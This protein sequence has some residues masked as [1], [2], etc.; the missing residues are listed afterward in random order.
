MLR[1]ALTLLIGALMIGMF[2][3]PVTGYQKSEV[4]AQDTLVIW[5]F[6]QGG[7]L[8]VLSSLV[9]GFNTVEP[10]IQARL[11]AIPQADYYA[12]LLAAIK[13][14]QPPDVAFLS[15]DWMRR[16]AG[17]GYIVPI[18]A[19]YNTVSNRLAMNLESWCFRP[20]E[21]GPGTQ[22]E[23]MGLPLTVVSLG[24]FAYSPP[25]F[26]K[27]GFRPPPDWENMRDLSGNFKQEQIIPVTLWSPCEYMNWLTNLAVRT[28]D[29]REM[30]DTHN[31]FRSDEF[32]NLDVSA[33]NIDNL[34]GPF[35]GEAG[36][37]FTN[38]EESRY[39]AATLGGEPGA[40]YLFFAFPTISTNQ[41]VEVVDVTMLS[42]LTKND[43]AVRYADKFIDYL[44]DAPAAQTLA[45]IGFMVP[46]QVVD[47]SL[48]T[49][50]FHQ[51]ILNLLVGDAAMPR[52]LPLACEAVAHR[53]DEMMFAFEES[54]YIPYGPQRWSGESYWDCV[55]RLLTGN[56]L[57]V[58]CLSG[59]ATACQDATDY[60][61]KASEAQCVF[62]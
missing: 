10:S 17:G 49:D 61:Q 21:R 11:E 22:V 6:W 53:Q 42:R 12:R 15:Y 25:F 1:H 26:Q 20:V 56:Q 18:A 37:A 36:M 38:S 58:D 44:T 5:T 29:E 3:A 24:V 45:G 33:A 41:D 9:R 52:F 46:N 4:Q 39:I 55:N 2:F 30:T 34:L 27:Y 57:M 51:F 31:L 54:Y 40:D 16:L 48:I 28:L 19:D 35:T 59:V 43:I 32:F 8:Q 13:A 7:D 23:L 14:D 47:W 50:P 60:F 62:W